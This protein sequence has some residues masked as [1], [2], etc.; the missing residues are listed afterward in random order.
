MLSQYSTIKVKEGNRGGRIII[1]IEE[2]LFTVGTV[3][4]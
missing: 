1:E 3:K 2:D 4:A